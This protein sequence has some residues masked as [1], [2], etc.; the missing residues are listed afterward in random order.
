MKN[1]PKNAWFAGQSTRG[2]AIGLAVSLI[3]LMASSLNIPLIMAAL[4]NRA[5]RYIFALWFLSSSS[6]YLSFISSPNLSRPRLDV[7]N[8]QRDRSRFAGA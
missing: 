1:S 8:T 7:Y 3:S 2:F 6:I 5:G 4:C